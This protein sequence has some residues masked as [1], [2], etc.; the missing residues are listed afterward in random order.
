[1]SFMIKWNQNVE[2]KRVYSY[3]DAGDFI[4]YI[5]PND[6]YLDI[7]KDVETLFDPSNYKLDKQMKMK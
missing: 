4:V 2:I 1:M 3:I 7:A 6:I 5:K